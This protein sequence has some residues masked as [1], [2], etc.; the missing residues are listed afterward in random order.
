M[1]LYLLQW[2]SQ[3]CVKLQ[4][5][6][7]LCHNRFRMGSSSVQ[8]STSQPFCCLK[9]LHHGLSSAKTQATRQ[10]FF[11]RTFRQLHSLDQLCN[12]IVYQCAK[13]RFE[14]LR[15]KETS[16]CGFW[17]D[18]Y[19][20][21]I[22]QVLN[23][24][25]SIRESLGLQLA[26][27]QQSFYISIENFIK[28]WHVVHRPVSINSEAI[29]RLLND[30]LVLFCR[31]SS[32]KDHNNLCLKAKNNIFYKINALEINQSMHLHIRQSQDHGRA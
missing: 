26:S 20:A 31:C 3:W 9:R 6:G 4:L 27:F 8:H 7:S 10:S 18:T 19:F 30:P 11:V 14:I 5:H 25:Y 22:W 24:S 23:A 15:M 1:P 21:G 29:W 28:F 13:F 32:N 12:S 17:G 16:S 2:C